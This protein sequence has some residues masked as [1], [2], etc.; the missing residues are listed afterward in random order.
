MKDTKD[1]V[2]SCSGAGYGQARTPE[3]RL[4]QQDVSR[5]GDSVARWEA[6]GGPSVPDNYGQFRSTTDMYRHDFSWGS[7][8]LR[9]GHASGRMP[10]E[11]RRR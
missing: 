1:R 9:W 4:P 6:G 7:V 2:F 10:V 8:M 11:S 3:V 5:Y